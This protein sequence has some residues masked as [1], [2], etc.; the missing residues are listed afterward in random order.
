MVTA[1]QPDKVL[2]LCPSERVVV[3]AHHADRRIDRIG[4]AESEEDMVQVRRREV[5]Q[6]RSQTDCG[7]AAEME[8]AGGARQAPHLL[9]RG[10]DD[11]FPAV[12]G[13]HAPQPGESIEEPVPGR[14][15][16]KAAIGGFENRNATP[17]MRSQRGDGMDEVRAIFL[18]KAVREHDRRPGCCWTHILMDPASVFSSNSTCAAIKN[19]ENRSAIAFYAERDPRP[20]R[21]V[22]GLRRGI[23]FPWSVNC[24]ARHAPSVGRW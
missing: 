14:V 22:R 8:I 13:I 1:L 23:P 20:P 15:G 16:D 10:R 18:N 6:L 21:G 2:F 3:V 17:F 12:A 19:A 7:F 5:C 11:A 4:P 9:H 24:C